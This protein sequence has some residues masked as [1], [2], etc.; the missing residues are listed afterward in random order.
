MSRSPLLMTQAPMPKT[1]LMLIIYCDV[2][3]SDQS[4]LKHVKVCIFVFAPQVRPALNPGLAQARPK[5]YR[6]KS[7]LAKGRSV[8]PIAVDQGPVSSI[9]GFRNRKVD[10]FTT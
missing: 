10:I 6:I 5:Q 3:K 4:F 2:L 9:L 7:C 8:K 1:F